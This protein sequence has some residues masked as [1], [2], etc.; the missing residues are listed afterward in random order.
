MP[1]SA[2]S[3]FD[4]PDPGR[5]PV[6]EEELAVP[7]HLL[8]GRTGDS[9]VLRVVGE[10]MAGE[11]VRDGDLVV[12]ERRRDVQSG[13]MVVALV[14]NKVTLKRFYPQGA[15]VRLQGADPED[16]PLVLPAGDVRVQGVV[17]GLMRKF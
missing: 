5:E 11:G 6:A 8:R 7:A 3:R 10:S 4:S 16:E 17:L 1:R 2:L 14:G 15:S 12:V 9:F 13:E